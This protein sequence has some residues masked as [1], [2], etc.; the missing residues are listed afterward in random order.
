M[1]SEIRRADE[2]WEV[3]SAASRWHAAGLL[4]DARLTAILE[5]YTDDRVRTRAGFR[6]LFFI[7]TFSA[8]WSF[9]GFVA[10]GFGDLLFDSSD[11]NFHRTIVSL[12]AVAAA[13]GAEVAT[14]RLRL[15]RFG[16]EEALVALAAIWTTLAVVLI[17][18]DAPGRVLAVTI[19]ALLASLGGVAAWRWGVPL[20]GALAAGG[21]FLALYPL[22]GARPLWIGAGLAL[23]VASFLGSSEARL[24]PAHRRRLDEVFVVAVAA[25]YAAVHVAGLTSDLFSL[26]TRHSDLTAGV[27]FTLRAL[28]WMAMTALPLALLAAGLSRRDR[29]AMALGALLAL[30]TAASAADALDLGPP[31]LVLGV[32]GGILVGL[33]L[34]LRRW[35]GSRPGR[36]LGGFTDRTLAGSEGGRSLLEL[37]ATV[38]AF[39]PEARSV[40]DAGG[41]RGGGG[42][43]GG[44][45]ASGEF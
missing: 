22:P 36:V 28:A 15:R 40:G 16:V 39:T 24:G 20:T 37:A 9:L 34:G 33:A 31:W 25:L 1:R 45:G 17:A 29:L 44:G 4:D 7:F 23:G 6:L 18:D 10:L 11:E 38:A 43:F 13:I 14:A 8:G 35:I 26:F 19:G 32:A 5:R 12:A 21:T 3:R 41:F 2:A 30:A 42:D 27:P